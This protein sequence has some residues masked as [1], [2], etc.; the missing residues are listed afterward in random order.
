MELTLPEHFKHKMR[1]IFSYE[2]DFESHV[3][4]EGEI[5]ITSN[6]PSVYMP[7]E[8]EIYLCSNL[9]CL[10]GTAPGV[11]LGKHINTGWKYGW[12]IGN[13]ADGMDFDFDPITVRPAMEII[14]E[15]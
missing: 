1:V 7:P 10:D 14:G 11:S 12:Y 8:H 5:F 6:K 13:T 15:I 4:Q 9:P 2:D 3:N